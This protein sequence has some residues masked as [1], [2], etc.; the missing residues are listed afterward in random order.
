MLCSRAVYSCIKLFEIK[1]AKQHTENQ[2]HR[3]TFNPAMAL[4]EHD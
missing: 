2:Q 4:Q 3:S 1:L